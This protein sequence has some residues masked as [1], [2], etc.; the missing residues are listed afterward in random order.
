MQPPQQL[1]QLQPQSPSPSPSMLAAIV[2][3]GGGGGSSN[4]SEWKARVLKGNADLLELRERI[5]P[6][7]P[8]SKSSSNA[9]ANA[10]STGPTIVGSFGRDHL[11]TAKTES[12]DVLPPH[13][14]IQ[15]ILQY[16]QEEGLLQSRD[17]LLREIFH[18][19]PDIVAGLGL[20]NLEQSR[21]WAPEGIYSHAIMPLLYAGIKDKK[22]LFAPLP[23]QT[24]EDA[25]VEAFE[26]FTSNFDDEAEEED[27]NIWNEPRQEGVNVILR[28]TREEHCTTVIAGTIN[29]FVCMLTELG[30]DRDM[31][32]QKIFFGIY[33]MFITPDRLLSKLLQRYQVPEGRESE[34][35][36]T[37]LTLALLRYWIEHHYE[38]FTES[39]RRQ[40]TNFL[41]TASETDYTQI[42]VAFTK[43]ESSHEEDNFFGFSTTPEPPSPKVPKIIFSSKLTLEDV[44]ASCPEQIIHQ[45][46]LIDYQ[47]FEKIKPKEFFR[48]AWIRCP[49]KSPNV[50]ALLRR[51]NTFSRWVAKCILDGHWPDPDE[52]NR[53]ST[54][55][56]RARM[57]SVFLRISDNLRNANNFFS[58]MAIFAAIMSE[59]VFK[60]L[61]IELPSQSGGAADPTLQALCSL[62][63]AQGNYVKYRQAM[64]SAKAPSIPYLG[65]HLQDLVNIEEGMPTKL[66]GMINFHQCVRTFSLV[67]DLLLWQKVRYNLQVIEQIAVLLRDIDIPDTTAFDK[68]LLDKCAAIQ[69]DEPPS[70]SAS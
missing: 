46:C 66:R 8:P 59:P 42:N 26:S 30:S 17:T 13:V 67:T 33:P 38:D 41:K 39:M 40:L 45:L 50:V 68:S 62:F 25:E 70:P 1:V 29:Q 63:S 57:L 18:S 12:R 49:H 19:I 7:L 65:V 32:F 4:K 3:G 9:N 53:V 51:F 28:P 56:D 22:D 52:P 15:L 48:R 60:A 37:T 24:E 69:R 5:R 20:S 64:L 6:L 54:H 2:G 47:L 36:V 34:Q 11:H 55:A 43:M 58:S 21:D 16:L 44:D 31:L 10:N 61:H 14:V 27:T 23:S 35:E